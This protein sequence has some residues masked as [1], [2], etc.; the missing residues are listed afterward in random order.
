ME[1]NPETNNLAIVEQL[2]NLQ[3]KVE[4]LRMTASE[5]ESQRDGLTK[6]LTDVAESCI[7]RSLSECLYC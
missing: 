1:D 7:N 2:D 6:I 3:V 5:L 4:Q